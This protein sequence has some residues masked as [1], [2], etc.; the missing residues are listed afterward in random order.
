G[1]TDEGTSLIVTPPLSV[2]PPL[3]EPDDEEEAPLLL[4]AP[5][6]APLLAPEEAPLEA[7]E[8]APLDAPDAP[9]EAPDE[10]PPLPPPPPLKLPPLAWQP[11]RPSA[12]VSRS[13]ATPREEIPNLMMP[14]MMTFPE[15]GL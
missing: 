4:L 11:A 8:D 14:F 15:P 10:A 9:E 13:A 3:D 12:A 7:P 2:G 5:E 6:E 1:T